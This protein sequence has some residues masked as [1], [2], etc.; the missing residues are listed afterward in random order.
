[1]RNQQV[2][3]AVRFRK[4]MLFRRAAPHECFVFPIK[5]EDEK[6]QVPQVCPKPTLDP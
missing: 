1:M 6:G 2:Q 3:A 4:E 5:A